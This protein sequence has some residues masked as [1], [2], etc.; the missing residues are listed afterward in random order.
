MH[1]A[2]QHTL[3]TLATGGDEHTVALCELIEAVGKKLE[4]SSAQSKAVVDQYFEQISSLR[5]NSS[6][7]S[8]SKFLLMDLIELRANGWEARKN[9]QQTSATVT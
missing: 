3:S 9:K 2:I 1:A 7:T 6:L 8:R 5:N 4:N